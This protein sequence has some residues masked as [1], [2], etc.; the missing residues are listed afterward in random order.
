M[1]SHLKSGVKHHARVSSW[2]RISEDVMPPCIKNLSNYRN[3]QLARMEALSDGYDTAFSQSPRGSGVRGTRGLRHVRRPRASWSPPCWQRHPRDI[4]RD[5]LIVLAREVLGLSGRGA[6]GRSDEPYLADEMFTCG[7]AAE[8]TPVVSVDHYQVGN[9]EIGPITT[10]LE[11][12]FDDVLRRDPRYQHWDARTR[13][14]RRLRRASPRAS[15]PAPARD[16]EPARSLRVG[17]SNS[18]IPG[19]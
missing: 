10:A 1:A 13:R 17:T 19:S 16:S 9:G 5:A 15:L 2:R 11:H 4:T 3:S 12:V 7:T 6:A 14:A 18:P 8:I